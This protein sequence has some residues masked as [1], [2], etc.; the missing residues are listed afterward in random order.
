LSGLSFS[1]ARWSIRPIRADATRTV[2][3]EIGVSEAL[4]A[5]LVQ[6]GLDDA[7]LASAFLSPSEADLLDP[8]RLLG[9]DLAVSRIRRAVA[10]RQRVR[11]VTDYD[12]D[13]TTS[14]LLLK[15]TLSALGATETVD[16]HIPDRFV[17]GYGF[18]TSA[19]RE[20][21]S[22]GIRLLITADVGIRD[23]EAISVAAAG[24]V[25]VIVCDHHLAEGQGVPHDAF[26]V[27][28]P[29]RPGESYPHAALAAVGVSLKLATALLADHPRSKALLNSFIK[30]AAIGTVADVADLS[31]QENRAIVTLGL[32]AL[33]RGPN[34]PGLRALLEVAGCTGRPL[35]ASDLGFRL[36]P[37]I[38]A[39]GRIEHAR[40]AVALLSEHDPTK[41]LALA[42][43]LDALNTQRKSLQ[44]RLVGQILSRSG[45]RGQADAPLFPVFSGPEDDGWHPGVVGIV[46]S[47]VRDT[48]FRPV[49]VA[50]VRNGTATGSIRSIPGVHAVQ[51]LEAASTML[52]RFGGHPAAAGFTL[53][54]ERLGDL[55][56]TLCRHVREHVPAEVLIPSFEADLAVRPRDLMAEVAEAFLRLAPFGKGNAEP[57]V[58]VGP[59]HPE[60]LRV[61]PNGHL[62]FRF[63]GI[64]AAWWGGAAF[65]AALGAGPVELLG[66]WQADDWSGPGDAG[67]GG[68]NSRRSY[69][70][71][72]TDARLS[73]PAT[74]P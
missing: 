7:S 45:P 50:A 55:E 37:R 65:A 35:D 49:A 21:V 12:V 43:E 29:S 48:L 71:N 32:R 39:A 17:E 2:A 52:L 73:D 53:P 72:V 51:A 68:E 24:G 66:K 25:D 41:A 18:S 69:R 33:E 44:A 64:R 36:G 8:Y 27:L 57:L 19:A 40:L 74:S 1:G 28:C 62:F 9:M 26:V 38:N 67:N 58:V 22:D 10:E 6:R 47:R 34:A 23:H 54:A 42:A 13:G 59:V 56:A 31:V 30:L 63:A 15:A 16:T 20:A 4:A 60:A 3:A 61:H 46:A 14:A 11:I 5:C 70:F